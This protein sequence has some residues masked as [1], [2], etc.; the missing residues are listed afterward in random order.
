LKNKKPKQIGKF[1]H[2]NFLKRIQYGGWNKKKSV[3]AAILD[4]F[5]L[6]FHKIFVLPTP[7]EYKKK[8]EVEMLD[9]GFF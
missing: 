6:N 2:F 4:F 7:N 1:L 3:I 8:I 5:F 9:T